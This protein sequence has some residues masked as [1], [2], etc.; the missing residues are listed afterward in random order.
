MIFHIDSTSMPLWGFIMLIGIVKKN[1]MMMIDFALS[2]ERRD[3]TAPEDAIFQGRSS[4]F[5]PS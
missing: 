4:V 5:D 3:G 1:A 2:A